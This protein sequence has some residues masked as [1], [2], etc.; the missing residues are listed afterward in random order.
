MQRTQPKLFLFLSLC[1]SVWIRHKDTCHQ[2]CQYYWCCKKWL[3]L[4]TCYSLHCVTDLGEPESLTSSTDTLRHVRY[5]HVEIWSNV[6]QIL[7]NLKFTI[8]ND[9]VKNPLGLGTI[10]SSLSLSEAVLE[11]VFHELLDSVIKNRVKAA[12][13]CQP[14]ERQACENIV[15]CLPPPYSLAL[16]LCDFWFFPKVKMT[17]KGKCFSW[18]RILKQLWR[19]YN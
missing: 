5:L 6:W 18:F 13:W 16:T 17:A 10:P 15:I 19:Q 11:V 9:I 4:E 12:A 14:M 2:N 8:V 7:F 3:F 1:L